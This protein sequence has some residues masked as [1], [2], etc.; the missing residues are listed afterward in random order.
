MSLPGEGG[1]EHQKPECG[2]L[3]MLP[4]VS[5]SLADLTTVINYRCKYNNLR[6]SQLVIECVDDLRD[7]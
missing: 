2:A 5:F 4:N 1:K 6:E 7:P 3:Q